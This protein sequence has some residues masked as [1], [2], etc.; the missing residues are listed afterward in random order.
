[1]SSCP[2]LDEFILEAGS[3]FRTI[4]A[5]MVGGCVLLSPFRSRERLRLSD[6]ARSAAA[7]PLRGPAS[8][9]TPAFG[10][11]RRT[12]SRIVRA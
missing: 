10:Q 2:G 5:R 4:A 11:S 12:P 1:L 9:P 6:M 3:K 8:L 7:R